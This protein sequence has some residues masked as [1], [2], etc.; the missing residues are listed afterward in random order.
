MMNAIATRLGSLRARSVLPL[1]LLAATLGACTHT[2]EEIVSSVPADYRQRH[3]IVVQEADRT[4]EVFVGT[5]RG[6]LT[7]SQRTDVTAFAQ[8]WLHEGIET[9]MNRYNRDREA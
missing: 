9:A 3:P 1:L 5:G 2:N 8:T 4:I 7:A 6:G